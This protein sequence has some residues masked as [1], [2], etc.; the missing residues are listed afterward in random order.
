MTYPDNLSLTVN[1]D[2][3]D[4]VEYIKPRTLSIESLL[5]RRVDTCAFVMERADAVKPG[6]WDEIVVLDGSD[7]VFAGYVLKVNQMDG[8]S[9]L[10]DYEIK[11]SDYTVFL[12][13]VLIKEEYEDTSDQD[14]I[15]DL[16]TD[17]MPVDWDGT[18]YVEK[19]KT[20][21]KIRFNR[22]T[23]LEV[24]DELA[25]LA[26]ADW[27]VDYDKQLH[28]FTSEDNPAPFSLSDS[29][30][31][32]SS[33][34]YYDLKIAEDHSGIVNRVEVIGGDYLSEDTTIYLQGTG[35][36]NRVIMPFRMRGPEA[37]GGI[38]V[39]RNDGSEVS[40]NWTTLTVKVGYIDSLGGTSE[41]LHYYQEQVL[42]QQNN[43]PD[44][45]NA[46][47]V[48]GRLEIP[49]RARVSSQAS[50]DALGLN[51]WFDAVIVDEDITDKNTA[52]LKGKAKLAEYALA[53]ETISCY[54][55]KPG[56]QSGMILTVSSTHDDVSD[57]YLIRSVKVLVDTNGRAVY[58][59]S[60]GVYDPDL[61]DIMLD[62][63]RRS[64]AKPIWRDDE[65]LD[66]LI[67]QSETFEF[68]S[69]TT[70]LTARNPSTNPYQW[71]TSLG[72]A[73]SW[74]WGY[75]KWMN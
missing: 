45:K 43:W 29:P 21:S 7:K 67:D 16:F 74:I 30:D 39:S 27:Y 63:V 72:A 13:K 48:F 31:E 6:G 47:R 1:I 5:T 19:I 46:V 35:Q 18:T 23:L 10:H 71:R 61:I 73:N 3:V 56:L 54:T 41:V 4:R 40:P 8:M 37:G 12:E 49:L 51:Q 22:M 57:D 42:E 36:D 59:L 60:L 69:E 34:P 53:R 55:R 44:L 20:H 33:Y 14:I 25:S 65:V 32:S 70:D 62:L 52:R 64:R 68:A 2:S 17:Y 28:F 75:G 15:D 66:D 26:G 50:Y 9:L 24:I 38:Q 11:C 58:N